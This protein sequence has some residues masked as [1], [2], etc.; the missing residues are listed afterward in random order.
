MF[1]GNATGQ[2]SQAIKA[3]ADLTPSDAEGGI[4]R[5]SLFPLPKYKQ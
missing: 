1:A 2:L 4:N 3:T 5:C